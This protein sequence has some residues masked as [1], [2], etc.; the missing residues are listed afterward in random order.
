MSRYRD[1][2]TR[3]SPSEMLLVGIVLAAMA[4]TLFVVVRWMATT[5]SGMIF[6]FVL[7]FSMLIAAAFGAFKESR[8]P[9]THEERLVS[10]RPRAEGL[11]KHRSRRPHEELIT[12][13]E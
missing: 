1:D 2:S 10:R 9:S 7:T 4:V 5:R 3:L 6:A 8:G 13:P 12:A 11:T